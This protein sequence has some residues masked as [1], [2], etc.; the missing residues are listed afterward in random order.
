MRSGLLAFRRERLQRVVSV[1]L[2][3]EYGHDAPVQENR[4]RGYGAE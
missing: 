3:G 2:I 1:D 4:R